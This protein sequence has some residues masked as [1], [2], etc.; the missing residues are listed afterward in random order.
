MKKLIL[1]AAAAMMVLASCTKTT[2]ESIDGP[3]EIAFKKIEGAMTKETVE[4]EKDLAGNTTMGVFAFNN[5][6]TQV[7]F[8]NTK[9]TLNGEGTGWAGGKYWPLNGDALDFVV[10]APYIPT[11]DSDG[12]NDIAL[13]SR[14]LTFTIKE[15]TD[16]SS[17]QL[18][19]L[20]GEEYYDS[21]DSGTDGDDGYN[22]GSNNVSVNLK[23]ALAKITVKASANANG[24]YTIRSLSINDVPQT[25]TIVVTY[26]DDNHATKQDLVE[27]V[28]CTPATDQ[29]VTKTYTYNNSTPLTT[30]A[31]ELG[32]CFAFPGNTPTTLTIT[33]T[34]A[35]HKDGSG[36]DII[37]YSTIDLSPNDDGEWLSGNNY[38]YTLNLNATEILFTPK[39]IIL[40]DVEQGS[41]N[42]EQGTTVVEPSTTVE[43]E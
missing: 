17:K 27:S 32:S 33:Y 39:V 9:F 36:K 35:G 20:Y 25:G 8:S 37:M 11:P 31:A 38:I 3:K 28:D 19:Y 12:K 34:M 41:T 2:V 42:V 6:T 4:I 5:G 1:T 13:S 29:V 24:T 22:K 16:V 7:Y 18:D 43:T 26:N 14:T 15:S 23:H 30:T 21:T 40:N 10:Y